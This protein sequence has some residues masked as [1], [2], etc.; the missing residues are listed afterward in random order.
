M[1]FIIFYIEVVILK[2]V[3]NFRKQKKLNYVL[4]INSNIQNL[5]D[6]I[7]TINFFNYCYYYKDVNN[8]VANIIYVWVRPRNYKCENLSVLI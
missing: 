7:K 4:V 6:E 2:S 1:I 3:V 5:H 8:D